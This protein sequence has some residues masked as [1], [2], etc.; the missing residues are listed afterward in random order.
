MKKY[1]LIGF[2]LGHSFSAK[3]FAEKFAKE[4]LDA[5]YDNY[6]MASVEGLRE[7]IAAD[8]E[9]CGL[10]V[11]IPHKQAVLPLLDE[12]SPEAR[13]IGAVNVIRVLRDSADGALGVSDGLR[14]IG[15]NSDVIG[16]TDSLRPLLKPHH[17]RALVLGTG[18]ASRAVVAGLRSL[19]IEPIYVSRRPV[20]GGL[21]YAQLTP[22]VLA[23][24]T[25]VVN[26]SPVGMYP[27]TDE[28]PAIPYE[29]LT[30]RHLLYDLVYN[31]L[32]TRFMQ[33][34]RERGAVVKNGL[35]MLHLQ[36]LAAWRMWGE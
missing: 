28:A 33:L 26:C 17:Q 22:D 11:T 15:C 20:E 6:E 16:F 32:D 18:G 36:A 7:L 10:N 23:A 34:G 2:P 30:P 27:K 21:T 29:L 9:L 25:V 24:H 31:P 19:G 4:G 1:G 3:F 8:S 35:E 5:R 13:A 12:L 14:L